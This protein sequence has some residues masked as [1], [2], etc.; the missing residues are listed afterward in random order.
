LTTLKNRYVIGTHVMFFEIEMFKDFIDG[1][2]NLVETVENKENVIVDLCFNLSEKLEKIDTEKIDKDELKS[3]FL[4]GVATLRSYVKVNYRIYEDDEFYYHADYRRDLNYNY[5]KKVDYVMWGETDSFFPRE[6]FHV[7]ETL[8]EYTNKENIHK[9]LLSFS[10]RKMWDSSWDPLV[11]KDY[12]H[13]EFI[14]DDEG[15]LNP[16]QAKSQLS[17]Q[18]MN[19]INA[20]AKEFEFT[21]I[22]KP[23]ISGACLVLSSDFI[24]SGVNIP[25]CLIYNDDEGL[26]IMSEKVLGNQFIQFICK[27]VLHV[28]ARRHPQ[29]RCYVANENNPHAFINKKVDNFQKFLQLSKA[30]VQRLITGKDKFYEYDDF[31]KELQ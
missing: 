25:S 31:E 30:N 17:I 11:H 27:N 26:S 13:L 5:C 9:Y 1:M 18:K 15:H 2:V 19:E 3:K 12:E 10:D 28:H 20:K 14:D 8:S 21:Y 6:A 7:I 4:S 23:K 16:N 22:T 24:K 29:K